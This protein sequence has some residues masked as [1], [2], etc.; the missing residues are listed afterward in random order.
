[1]HDLEP[2]Y[3][4]RDYYIA[5]EDKLSPYYGHESNEFEFVNK[6]YNFYIHP[7]WDDFGSN[8]L[9]LKIL[10][11]DYDE[12]F[13]IIEL[14]GEWND[15]LHNDIMELKRT[16]I[17]HQINHGITKFILIGE[18]VLNFHSS[19]DSYYEEWYEDIKDEAGW[20]VLLG[21]LPHVMEEMAHS[22]LYHFMLYGEQWNQVNWRAFTPSQLFI[23]VDKFIENPK[24]LPESTFS[25]KR[26]K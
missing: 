10:Y 24:T 18:Q 12:G 23:L 9:Y 14:L 11:A 21:L 20:I 13:T 4:W 26:I 22:R 16:I 25:H 1:M 7:Q 2:Y 19:D 3:Q 17:D 8:T 6:V 5:S 15:A